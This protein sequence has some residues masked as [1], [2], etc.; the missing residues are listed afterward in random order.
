MSF[1][2]QMRHKRFAIVEAWIGRYRSQ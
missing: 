1:V 2:P